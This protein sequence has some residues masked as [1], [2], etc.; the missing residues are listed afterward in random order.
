MIVASGLEVHLIGEV[1]SENTSVIVR[2]FCS[3]PVFSARVVPVWTAM[4]AQAFH[5]EIEVFFGEATV[6]WHVTVV[7]CE[8]DET[9][10]IMELSFMDHPYSPLTAPF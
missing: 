3:F 6:L 7:V 1:D 8:C 5:E 10:A 4:M 2:A 9:A